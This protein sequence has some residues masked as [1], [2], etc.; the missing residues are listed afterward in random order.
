MIE[1]LSSVTVGGKKLSDQVTS[2]DVEFSSRRV[3]LDGGPEIA[4]IKL[5]YCTKLG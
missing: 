2:T 1:Y 5:M 4:D 3:T